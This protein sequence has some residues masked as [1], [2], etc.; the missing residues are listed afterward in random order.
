MTGFDLFLTWLA[1]AVANYLHEILPQS[2]TARKGRD[3]DRA[4]ERSYFQIVPLFLVWL[5]WGA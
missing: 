2:V 5:R 4:T 1:V 3:W